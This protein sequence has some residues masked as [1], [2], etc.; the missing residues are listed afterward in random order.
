M[1]LLMTSLGL[2][3]TATASAAAPASRPDSASAPLPELRWTY[4]GRYYSLKDCEAD[5]IYADWH[6][7]WD[8]WRCYRIPEACRPAYYELYLGM[9]DR[10]AQ[11]PVRSR[12][13]ERPVT[14]CADNG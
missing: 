4:A 6:D 7:G 2:T 14:D 3:A 11:V 9:Y 10:L 8:A 12:H 1:L 5:G 13:Q